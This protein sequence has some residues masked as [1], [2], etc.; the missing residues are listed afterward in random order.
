MNLIWLIDAIKGHRDYAETPYISVGSDV[1][2]N[3]SE[4]YF[5]VSVPISV[6]GLPESDWSF[7][8]LQSISSNLNGVFEIDFSSSFPRGGSGIDGFTDP[9]IYD[10][11]GTSGKINLPTSPTIQIQPTQFSLTHGLKFLFR[12]EFLLE[13]M[14]V[15][16]AFKTHR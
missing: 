10:L 9:D 6:I 1:G 4:N 5:E 7:A 2:Q 13:L 14:M 12:K 8:V 15:P 16:R 3:I 11:I